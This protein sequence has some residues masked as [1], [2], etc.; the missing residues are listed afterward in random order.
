MSWRGVVRRGFWHDCV[1]PQ[2]NGQTAADVCIN[3][4]K[5]LFHPKIHPN[6]NPPKIHPLLLSG[7]ATAAA[8]TLHLH[9]RTIGC[10]APYH[11]YKRQAERLCTAGWKSSTTTRQ[12]HVG[13]NSNSH[14]IH[15]AKKRAKYIMLYYIPPNIKRD[16]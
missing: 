9:V 2:R 6:K 11:S 7:P 8:V 12:Q 1:F 10:R 14:E 5:F 13:R 15:S 4:S 3:K 16:K